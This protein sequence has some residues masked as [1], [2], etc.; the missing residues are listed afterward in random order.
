[1]ILSELEY[2]L[3]HNWKMKNKSMHRIRSQ[4]KTGIDNTQ[5]TMISTITTI[6]KKKKD[7]NNH[8]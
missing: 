3:K 2:R 4:H 1:M 8:L 5:L 6:Q 7:F